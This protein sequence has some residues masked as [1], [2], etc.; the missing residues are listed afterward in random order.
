MSDIAPTGKTRIGIAS[1]LLATLISLWG[2]N[3]A[4]EEEAPDAPASV[5]Q[6]SPSD[7]DSRPASVELD[8]AEWNVRVARAGDQGKLS[9]K[10]KKRVAVQRPRLERVVRS[11]YDSL[12]LGTTRPRKEIDARFSQPARR[13]F[14]RALFGVPESVRRVKT[15]RRFARIA[16][17]VGSTRRA[18]AAITIRARGLR[19]SNVFRVQ[20]H[21]RLWL[22]R[23][24]GA[25]RVIGFDARQHPLK[26]G[27]KR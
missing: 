19:G 14:K 17:Q 18:S 6:E 22:E 5:N 12:F 3:S 20:H 24:E 23:S 21:A 26:K 16:I 27:A 4:R 11:L 1:L 25:W 7:K 13:A 15:L 10:V 9:K 2:C 8:Q